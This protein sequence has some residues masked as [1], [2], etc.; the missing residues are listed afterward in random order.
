MTPLTLATSAH[1]EACV[2]IPPKLILVR[3][4]REQLLPPSDPAPAT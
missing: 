4:L 1:L 3:L 2:Y